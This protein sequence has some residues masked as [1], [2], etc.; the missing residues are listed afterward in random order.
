MI[1]F[2]RHNFGGKDRKN[3]CLSSIS[4]VEKD[5]I[6]TMV[7]PDFAL[8]DHERTRVTFMPDEKIV[9]I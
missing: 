1:E 2:S 3:Y 5:S 7:K 8:E 9:A 4:F 6:F